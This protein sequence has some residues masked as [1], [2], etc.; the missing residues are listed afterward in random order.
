MAEEKPL[1]KRLKVNEEINAAMKKYVAEGWRAKKE[2]EKICWTT[3][4]GTPM[5]LLHAMDIWCYLPEV[6]SAI[7]ASDQVIVQYQTLA[8]REGYSMDSICPYTRGNIGEIISGRP[9]GYPPGTGGGIPTPDFLLSFKTICGTLVYWWEA[10]KRRFGVPLFVGDTMFY[11]RPIEDHDVKYYADSMRD[12]VNFLEKHTGKKLDPERLK[13]AQELSGKVGELMNKILEMNKNVPAPL[14]ELDFMSTALA[15]CWWKGC[16]KSPW[17]AVEFFEK[18]LA[19]VE[20]RVKNRIGA[21]EDEKFRLVFD[22]NP[23]WYKFQWIGDYL[24]QK[25]AIYVTSSFNRYW[26]GYNGFNYGWCVMGRDW[27]FEDIGRC[28]IPN[29][30]NTGIEERI[31][32]LSRLVK[33]YRVDAGIFM[34]N[35]GCRILSYS[36]L[37][38]AT[39]LERELG[40]PTL[41]YEGSMADP[42]HFDE[43]KVKVQLDTFLEMLE[44]KKKNKRGS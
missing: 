22:S 2:G 37:D 30:I 9:Q 25:G 4:G 36:M 5:E 19:E 14:D 32:Y 10:L 12:C 3:G 28:G 29:W 42:R 7:A 43:E 27:S 39:Y 11:N 38:E 24:A 6:Q 26:T 35:R 40:I 8:E 16:R 44:K 17:N 31:R 41:L 33:D 1:V 23:P 13:E 18:A 34:D 21:L 15:A 20:E